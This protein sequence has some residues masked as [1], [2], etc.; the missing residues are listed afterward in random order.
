MGEAPEAA[1]A[2]LASQCSVCLQA[3]QTFPAWKPR[4]RR[5][6][7]AGTA[8][9]GTFGPCGQRAQTRRPEGS[10]A[11][12]RP[13]RR[14]QQQ[15]HPTQARA[16]SSKDQIPVGKVAHVIGD[17]PAKTAVE[18]TGLP[19]CRNAQRHHSPLVGEF[20]LRPAGRGGAALAGS[21]GFGL[22]AASPDD[23]C[24]AN[25]VHVARPT[26]RDPH[27]AD[28]RRPQFR[29]RSGYHVEPDG[30][31]PER[32]AGA[33]RVA[34]GVAATLAQARRSPLCIWPQPRVLSIRTAR[35]AAPMGGRSSARTQRPCPARLLAEALR[36]PT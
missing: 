34:A 23:T 25:P 8:G 19:L 22:W 31:A 35:R 7:A 32:G 24:A 13:S 15:A 10:P 6:R 14:G 27:R 5:G 30:Q 21:F 4:A 26:W 12:R 2:R 16:L 17:E 3:W 28:G 1:T 36:S 11:G 9:P 33:A 18:D 29:T 20:P